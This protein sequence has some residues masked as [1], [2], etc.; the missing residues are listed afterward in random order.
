M[1]LSL[2]ACGGKE[3]PKPQP[4]WIY[5]PESVEISYKTDP[6]LNEFKGTSHVLQLVI[7][8]LDSV[9]KFQELS[10]YKDGLI[11]L[12]KA[13]N[14]DPSVTSV[15]KI[16]LD[17]GKSDKIVFDRAEKSR[18]VAFAAGFFDLQPGRSTC[19]LEIPYK[20]EKKGMIFFKK[21]IAVIPDLKI[22]LTLAAH[23]IKGIIPDE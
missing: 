22:N 21:E 10:A 15:Q 4:Q 7:Y 20:I 1:F 12:L 18:W 13:Q 23:D 9:N 3:T 11:K 16:F 17:P 2:G 19:I 14:F 6:M 5:K 8:Q